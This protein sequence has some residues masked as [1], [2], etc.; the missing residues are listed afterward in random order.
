MSEEQKTYRLTAKGRSAVAR[1]GRVP[2]PLDGAQLLGAVDRL[3]DHVADA[4]QNWLLKCEADGLIE[5]V[6]APAQA[7]PS[8]GGVEID[9]EVSWADISLTRLGVYLSHERVGRRA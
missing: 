1:G 6:P 5:R 9:D 2:A 7:A 4:L 8:P 3:D